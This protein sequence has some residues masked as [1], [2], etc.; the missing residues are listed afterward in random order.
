MRALFSLTVVVA[1]LVGAPVDAVARPPAVAEFGDAF[2][3]HDPNSDAWVIGST[4]LEVTIGFDTSRTLS[5]QKLFNP[6]TGRAWDVTP[7][8]EAPVAL[9]ASTFNLTASG[10]STSLASAE[11]ATTDAGVLLTFTF[12]HHASGAR[13]RRFYA[14]YP[15]SATI[16]T[17]TRIDATAPVDVSALVGWRLTMANAPVRWLGGLRGDAAGNE[18]AGAFELAERGLD[19]GERI[20]IGSDRRS[21]EQ[22]VPFVVVDDGRDEFFG[23]LMWSAAWRIAIERAGD[24]LNVSAFVPDVTTAATPAHAVDL[25]HTFFGVAAHSASDEPGALQRFVMNG[26]RH[27]R[28]LQPLVTYNTWFAYGVNVDED[29]MVAEMDLAASLGVELF[30]LDA[31]W[32]VG[33]GQN[34]DFDFDSGLGSWT[35]D[36]GRFPSSLASLA[37]YAHGLGMKFGLW[38]EPARVALSTVDRPGLARQA[39]LATEGG[40]FGQ[41]SNAQICLVHA[42][43]YAWVYGKLAALVDQ[44]RP[45]YLKWDDNLW[46]NCDRTGHGH[47]PADGAFRHVQALYAMLTALRL[48]YPDLTIENVSGGGNRLDFGMLALTDTAWMDDR[49][50]PADHVRHN[51]EGLTFAYPPAYLLSFLI[52]A[53]GEPIP[54]N[55]DLPFAIRSRMPGILGLTYRASE[56]DDA[57][58]GILRAEIARYKGIRATIADANATLLS[59]QAPVDADAWDVL[60][61]IGADRRSAVIFA[62]KGNASDGRIVVRPRSLEADATYDVESFDAGPLGSARGEAL[63]ADGIELNHTP[64]MS[65]AHVIVL[66]AR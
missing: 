15:G 16:E 30:V 66:T 18:G 26:V 40:D 58:A 25:P 53:D 46:V 8:P 63:M 51:L 11:A 52:D 20:E 54:A 24:R 7:G 21:T 60:Q 3:A 22:F 2:V 12:D 39:W 45:D 35:V 33:A 6:T 47:G 59:A 42:D 64:A 62:F 19:A 10:G 49:T 29:A 28:P 48:R 55:D 14:S 50:S 5:I 34:G 37:D 57:T 27:G 32:Y 44:V 43:A 38:V 23:G 9:G 36:S 61:E 13:V 41:P 56:I 31:G 1:A 17:W 4:D 65:R